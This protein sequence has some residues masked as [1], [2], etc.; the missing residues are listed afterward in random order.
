VCEAF[1][2]TNYR[3]VSGRLDDDEK[4]VSQIATP[5]GMQNM[6]V[7]SESGL[8]T[9]LF[10]MQ[11]EKAR[12]VS[13]EYIQ[14]RIEQLR[15]F[16]RWVTHE[17]LPSIRRTGCYSLSQST[18]HCPPE[19]SPGGLA[20]LILAT[21]KVM[22]EAGNSPLD[23]REATRNIYETWCIPVPSVLMKQLPGQLSLFDR[24][25]LEQ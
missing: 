4:G 5:G 2:E 8:H 17:V 15:T 12:G 22:L 20:K 11:P 23:V 25:A 7:V 19:V 10:Y 6:V 16:R 24:P 13:D 9:T 3:R 14:N 1:G 21:R 18:L